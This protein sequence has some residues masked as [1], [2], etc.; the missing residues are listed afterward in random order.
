MR[1][2]A[3]RLLL[4]RM[5]LCRDCLVRISGLPAPAGDDLG[6]SLDSRLQNPRTP[7]AQLTDLCRRDRHFLCLLLVLGNQRHVMDRSDGRGCAAV[8]VHRHTPVTWRRL[9][10]SADRAGRSGGARC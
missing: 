7:P 5:G 1:G 3:A 10:G 9:T 8:F 2:G 4:V 6:R